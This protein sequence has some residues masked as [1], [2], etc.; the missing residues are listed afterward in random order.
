MKR[1]SDLQTTLQNYPES[2][3]VFSLRG[4]RA[5]S[6]LPFINQAFEMAFNAFRENANTLL[7]VA[8]KTSNLLRSSDNHPLLPLIEKDVTFSGFT[9]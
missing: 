5:E 1:K 2:D 3:E 8:L 9:G 4:C 7:I 6:S